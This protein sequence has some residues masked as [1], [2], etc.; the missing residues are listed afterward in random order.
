MSYEIQNRATMSLDSVEG[1][2]AHKNRSANFALTGTELRI[3]E[4]HQRRPSL[5]RLASGWSDKSALG[6]GTIADERSGGGREWED[7]T[8]EW[9][10]HL[11]KRKVAARRHCCL[12][13]DWA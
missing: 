7:K 1:R 2:K 11:E 9:S 6:G 3:K 8:K 13:L 4:E 12:H 10:F 5:P